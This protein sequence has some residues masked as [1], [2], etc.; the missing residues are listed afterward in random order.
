MRFLIFCFVFLNLI[1]SQALNGQ[2]KMEW[3]Q[4]NPLV[5]EN[6]MADPNENSPFYAE[7]SSGIS[8]SYSV[9]QSNGKM[10]FDFDVKSFFDPT[11]SWVK[12][13]EQSSY[14]LGH[15]KLH[16]DITELHARKLRKTFSEY[17]VGKNYKKELQ[18]IYKKFQMESYQMQRKFDAETRHSI[19][20]E[21]EMEWRDFVKNELAKFEEYAL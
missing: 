18:V 4:N 6:F 3:D 15:E 12:A 20:R 2:E 5:W 11:G 8:Q 9:R 10:E 1:V 19:N 17:N 7:T 13:G 16:F 21:A 14:L